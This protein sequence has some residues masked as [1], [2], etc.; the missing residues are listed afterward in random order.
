[1]QRP[2]SSCLGHC[3]CAEPLSTATCSHKVPEADVEPAG[4]GIACTM[5]MES[6][7]RL[8]PFEAWEEGEVLRLTLLNKASIDN[9]VIKDILR[10]LDLLDPH[11]RRPVLVEQEDLVRMTPEARLLL[12]RACR[13]G[14]RPV[15]FLAHD[16][17]ERIQAE[18][19]AR[20]HRPAFPFRV[21][22][23]REEAEH[24]LLGQRAVKVFSLS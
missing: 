23:F 16:I 4:A 3:W 22:G 17:P 8:H 5:P 1:M 7:P 21:F 24:W 9:W 19:F 20:F 6:G 13:S 18:F 2:V 11:G 12:V 15:A 14:D 10:L